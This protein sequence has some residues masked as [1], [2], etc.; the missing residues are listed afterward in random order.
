MNNFYHFL[1]SQSELYGYMYGKETQYQTFI[2]AIRNPYSAQPERIEE[3]LKV[4][5]A[6]ALKLLSMHCSVLFSKIVNECGISYFET[7]Y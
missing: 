2:R 1:F 3:G 5:T 6:F 7:D 4:Q